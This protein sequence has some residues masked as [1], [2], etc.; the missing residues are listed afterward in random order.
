VQLV[1]ERA[2]SSREGAALI[3]ELCSAIRP[4]LR[5]R[6]DAGRRDYDDAWWVEL[7]RGGPMGSKRV[8]P[9]KS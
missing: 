3:G 9:M 4:E 2:T 1:L 6:H 7:A 8:A 5:F